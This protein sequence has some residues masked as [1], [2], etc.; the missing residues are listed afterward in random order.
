MQIHYFIFCLSLL[1][2]SLANAQ[3]IYE[4][5]LSQTDEILLNKLNFHQGDS[6][7]WSD[8][9]YNDTNWQVVLRQDLSEIS[10]SIYWLRAKIV[11]SGNSNEYDFIQI[12]IL[13]LTNAYKVY[14]DGKEILT[15]GKIG[16]SAEDEKLGFSYATRK[17]KPGEVKEGEHT[18]AVRVS[19][20]NKML[21]SRQGFIRFGYS[22]IREKAIQSELNQI[23]LFTGG[24]SIAVLFT[25][26]LFIGNNKYKAYLFLLFSFL[27]I[28]IFY[29]KVYFQITTRL[30]VNYYNYLLLSN[31]LILLAQSLVSVAFILYLFEISRKYLHLIVFAIIVVICNWIDLIFPVIDY[32]AINALESMYSIGLL[33][34]PIRKIKPGSKLALIGYTQLF[35]L[36]VYF[37]L[38][39]ISPTFRIIDPTILFLIGVFIFWYCLITAV[40]QKIK[41]Q[42]KLYE[43]FRLHSLRLETDLLRKS[44]Q[45]HFI[46][47]TLASIRSLI[48]RKP[49][50]A[51]KLINALAAEYRLINK[52]SSEKE[53][54][55]SQEIEL[56]ESHLELMG[57]RLEAKYELI[58]E[59]IDYS[60]KVPPLLFHTLIENGL[61]H[62]FNPKEDGK[63]WL[64]F[65][66]TNNFY[67]YRLLNNG[68]LL[69]ENQ[70]E[71]EI[72]EGTGIKYVKTRLEERYPNKWQLTY[73]MKN[74]LWEVVI[75]I[76]E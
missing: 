35:L 30:P 37:Y 1:V 74:D 28:L 24:Y 57:Y 52:I 50:D 4:F 5:N 6:S 72:E 11:L 33:I 47:N 10:E 19:N 21:K 63:F 20:F 9:N 36:Y 7:H 8:P 15:N 2:P 16:V 59:N 64:T 22:S 27:L 25:L 40:G 46:I 31:F 42:N 34:V 17:L 65:N 73:G 12:S 18:L 44:I 70:N 48:K 14:W 41:Y 13:N 51:E 54:P 43:E 71:N 76:S 55:I 61:T 3:K 38:Y 67:E 68:S 62:A 56:C 39:V 69:K 60:L 49:D 32:H 29:A 45:P 58:K 66:K 53:I 26:M 23:I 75:K